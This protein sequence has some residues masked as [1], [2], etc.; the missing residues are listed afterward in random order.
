MTGL[1]LKPRNKYFGGKEMKKREKIAALI[2]SCVLL[3]LFESCGGS[4]ESSD[5]VAVSTD[6]RSV[7]GTPSA[8]SSVVLS[9]TMETLSAEDPLPMPK[10]KSDGKL[11]LGWLVEEMTFES[12]ARDYYQGE[13]ECKERGWSVYPVLDAR[14]IDKQ[15]DA[16]EIFIRRNLDAIVI[17]YA[18]M[19]SIKDLVIQAR[20]KGIGVYCVDNS[21][22]PGVI[23]NATQ[24]NGVVGSR[25]FY[26]G[27][28]KL[29][30]RGKV[31][32]MNEARP[33]IYQER[34]YA[35]EGILVNCYPG[36]ELVKH[37]LCKDL[38]EY[39][40]KAVDNI[41][42]YGNELDWI[43][44]YAD[45]DGL[46]AIRAVEQAGF[47]RDDI[48]VTGVD[49]GSQAFAM[50]RDGSPLIAT[51][52]QPFEQ[53]THQIFEII[54]E[55]QVRGIIPGSSESSIPAGRIFYFDSVLTTPEN[56]PPIGASIHEVF[57]DTYYD[58]SNKDAW[59]FTGT[60]YVI[61]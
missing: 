23:A 44:V 11:E 25:M 6:N 26:Y 52:S 18:Q 28:E 5:S 8:N 60:P 15:R 54:D 42:K 46:G 2:I 40:T 56:V 19:E 7:S 41:T 36:M 50:I 12:F 31:L 14:T 21:I 17:N 55:V 37:E 20:E 10:V 4:S 59:Y 39:Y 22:V 61:Q 48:F 27:M 49:G 57:K 13:L 45:L 9:G 51:M 33:V 43:F 53:Y 32:F 34:L 3:C 58:P 35:A 47:T 38:E 1:K 30:G 29:N 16:M 24:Y